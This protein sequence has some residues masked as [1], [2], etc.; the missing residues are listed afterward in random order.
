[1]RRRDFLSLGGGVAL[2]GMGQSAVRGQRGDTPPTPINVFDRPSYELLQRIVEPLVTGSIVRTWVDE[3]S[4][5]AAAKHRLVDLRY[6]CLYVMDALLEI[7]EVRA[8]RLF[9]GGSDSS[10]SFVDRF[11]AD[12]VSRFV[13]QSR[14]AARLPWLKTI[15]VQVPPPRELGTADRGG[16]G[17]AA[18]GL[19]VVL[20]PA[21]SIGTPCATYK[22][23]PKVPRLVVFI[24]GTWAA[25]ELWWRAGSVFTNY[26]DQINGGGVVYKGP[27]PFAWS[28]ANDGDERRRAA[29][30]FFRWYQAN[31]TD[32]LTVIAH[33]HGGNVAMWATHLHR[34]LK[35]NRLVLMG[36]P[37][38]TDF[39]PDLRQVKMLFNVYTWGDLIQASGAAPY[40]RGD[41]R[42]LADSERMIN[43]PVTSP[44]SWN[45]VTPHSNL[46]TMDVWRANG[47]EQFTKA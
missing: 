38:R 5:L 19:R 43:L 7:D 10:A 21:P 20:P 18:G 45:G 46:H 14:G 24:A 16:A 39:V 13:T 15:P 32:D 9:M 41:A 47:L 11:G 29:E 4:L 25:N 23:N 44:G 8:R 42:T 34:E 28:C 36:T 37:M 31:P 3:D 40:P 12:T 35:V 30:C 27:E 6:A 26:I 33:S 17:Q 22:T 1:M 2:A